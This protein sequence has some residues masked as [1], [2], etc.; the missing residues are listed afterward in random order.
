MRSPKYGTVSALGFLLLVGTPSVGASQGMRDS[1]EGRVMER[2]MQNYRQMARLSDEQARILQE[3]VRESFQARA[4]L[5]RTE[6]DLWMALEGELRPGVAADP[7]SL[8]AL[9]DRLLNLQQQHV[10]VARSE[11]ARFAEF[12][13]PVQRALLTTHF[14]RLQQQIERVR[15]EQG[16][17]MMRRP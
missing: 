11:Q 17:P 16:P 6:R 14:R 3:V 9:L 8:V 2:F 12:L 15:M 13:T 10:E 4:E 5:R 1:L 7:D